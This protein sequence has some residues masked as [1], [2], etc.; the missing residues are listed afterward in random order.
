MLNFRSG[1]RFA[2]FVCR[3]VPLK[4]TFVPHSTCEMPHATIT[5]GGA[6]VGFWG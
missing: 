6:R 2:G 3:C 1:G 4:Q 5:M